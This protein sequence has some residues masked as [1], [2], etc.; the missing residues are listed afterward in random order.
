MR[1]R[2]GVD[3]IRSACALAVLV[4][5]ALPAHGAEPE[6]NVWRRAGAGFACVAAAPKG[7][8]PGAVDPDKLALQC[9]HMGPFAIGGEA[10]TLASVLGPPHRTVP[11]AKGSDAMV[12]FLEQRDHYPYFVATVR[13]DRI[14]TLQVTGPDPAK[15]YSFN[16]VNLGDSTATLTQYFGPAF[17]LSKSD[18]PETD[19]WHYGPWP[20]SFEV[21]A[22]RVTSIRIVDP[23]P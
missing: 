8:P 5:A 20:F 10:R 23:A 15:G 22:G 7:A 18:L 4:L 2:I 16:H 1:H 6:L 17:R 9:M 11:Q 12:W 14:A 3:L 21:K 13:N 19:V